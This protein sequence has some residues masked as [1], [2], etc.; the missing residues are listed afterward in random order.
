MAPTVFSAQTPG[1]V[2]R[3]PACVK[4]TPRVPDRKWQA[5]AKARLTGRV[6]QRRKMPSSGQSAFPDPVGVE[7]FPAWLVRALI[8]MSTEIVP[9]SLQQVRRQPSSTVS[10]E[11]RQ[12]SGEAGDRQTELNGG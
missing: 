3:V 2:D 5:H 8:G 10:V 6:F 9:L 1:P 11:V 12:C 7:F 4:I